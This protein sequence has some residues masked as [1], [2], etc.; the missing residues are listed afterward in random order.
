MEN[1]RPVGRK[2]SASGMGAVD[3]GLDREGSGL[4]GCLGVSCGLDGVSSPVA[5]S[6]SSSSIASSPGVVVDGVI[7]AP[8]FS[9]TRVRFRRRNSCAGKCIFMGES[10]LL[11]RLDRILLLAFLLPL[12]KSAN[13]TNLES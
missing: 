3:V 7:D 11:C 12:Y 1:E 8:S 9:M 2:G 10:L 5:P 13:C 6:E 4:C